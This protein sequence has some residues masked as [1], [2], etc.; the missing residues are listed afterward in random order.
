M[1]NSHKFLMGVVLVGSVVLL[2]MGVV[3]FFMG[4]ILTSINMLIMGLVAG[5]NYLL[6]KQWMRQL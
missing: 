1:H 5:A 4:N 2:V 3:W 6:H